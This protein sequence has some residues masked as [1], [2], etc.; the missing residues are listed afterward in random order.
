MSFYIDKFKYKI[1][2]K[3]MEYPY[4]YLFMINNMDYKKK[5]EVK[6][7]YYKEAHYDRCKKCYQ[8]KGKRN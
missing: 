1:Y 4:A 7:K 5:S 2:I 8:R 6:N 3:H